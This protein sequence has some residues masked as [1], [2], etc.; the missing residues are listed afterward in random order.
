[1]R[2]K[3]I[4]FRYIGAI[5][6]ISLYFSFLPAQV[7]SPAVAGQFYPADKNELS[8]AVKDYLSK[9]PA[10]ITIGK[11][12]ELYGVIVPHAGYVF[13]AQVAAYGF[14]LLKSKNIDTVIML[15]Q[16]HNFPLSKAAVFT[17]TAFRT[18]LGEVQVDKELAEEIV[19]SSKDLFEENTAAHKPEHSLEVEL[20]FCRRSWLILKL[21]LF[22]FLLL[23]WRRARG[24]RMLLRML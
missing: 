22:L 20:P 15:G 12:E 24:L 9:V 6:I 4:G 17:D 10:N 19:K 14:K 8:L 3:N 1:M 7:R 5:C 13:S 11:D 18:P 21:Y 16:S 2:I 23:H